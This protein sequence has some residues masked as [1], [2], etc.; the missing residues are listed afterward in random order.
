MIVPTT[1]P[2]NDPRTNEELF[3]ATLE[4]AYDDQEPWDAVAALR[5]RGT[6]E[7]FELAKRKLASPEPRLRSRALDVLAQLGAGKPESERPF[8]KESVALA[9]QHARDAS[10]EVVHSAAWALAHLGGEEAVSTL[11]LM[12]T[13]TDS[14]VRHAVAFGMNGV[15]D[16]RAIQALIELM[17]GEDE[18]VRD[19]ATFAISGI[20]PADSPEIRAALRKRLQD[21]FED[22]RC[23]A[24]WGLA[25]RK[26]PEGLRMVLERLTSDQWVHG[27]EM[28]AVD[29]LGVDCETP[30]E[31]LCSGLRRLL[32]DEVSGSSSV[33]P[34]STR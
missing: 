32:G 3:A 26:D 12:K 34:P 4:G 9:I 31:D 16:S 25:V 13:N 17:E 10:P 33:D 8:L 24:I 20:P 11:L 21:S 23:E 27:D 19:W 7:V 29:A 2:R 5:L 18:D 22:A 15:A 1:Q 28:A 30:I 6:N 14:G